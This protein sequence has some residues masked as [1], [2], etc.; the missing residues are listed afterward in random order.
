MVGMLVYLVF[1]L[2]DFL[3]ALRFI[4]LLLGANPASQFVSWVYSW[5]NPLVA[6][7]NGIFGQHTTTTVH[8]FVT[9]G[10]FDWTALIALVVYGLIGGIISK[11]A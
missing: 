9:T 6:P 7:F 8:G 5:S 10:V 4:F 2:V 11:I 1:G 3:I